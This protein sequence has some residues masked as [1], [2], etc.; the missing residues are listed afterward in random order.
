[1]CDA[2][3]FG[4]RQVGPG[5]RCPFHVQA[6]PGPDVRLAEAAA[7]AD[8]DLARRPSAACPAPFTPR[9]YARL[10]ILRSRVHAGLIPRG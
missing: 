10:L 8:G 9:E 7:D 4:R 1:M 2:C 5:A 6:P 3:A